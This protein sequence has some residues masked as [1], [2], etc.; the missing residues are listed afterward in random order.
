M[1]SGIIAG[2]SHHAQSE[3]AAEQHDTRV[4][5]SI[6]IIWGYMTEC[7]WYSATYPYCRKTRRGVDSVDN[8]A[9]CI[10]GAT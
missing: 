6:V 9:G 4:E 3:Q 1:V 7:V 2:N 10:D 5:S 8:R